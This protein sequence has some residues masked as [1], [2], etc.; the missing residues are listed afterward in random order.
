MTHHVS[1]GLALAGC[2]AALAAQR[3]P[4]VGDI[5]QRVGAYVDAYGGR[6]SIV[7]ATERYEQ[8]A[9][10]NRDAPARREIVSEFAIAMIED[11]GWQGFRDVVEVDGKPL[12]DRADRL[13]RALTSN[14]GSALAARQLSDESARFNIG[15]TFRNFN[16]PTTALFFFASRNLD[17]FKVSARDV[18]D[19][20]WRV[21]WRETARPTFIRTPRNDSVPTEGEL[22]VNPADGTIRRTR[23]EVNVRWS[24]N[25]FGGGR[26]DVSYQ[27]VDAI[28]MWLPASMDEQWQTTDRY[29][30]WERASGHAVYSNYRQFTTS[31]RIK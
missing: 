3:V 8:E 2:V 24:P 1:R 27:F 9:G 15:R 17:R 10:G 22:W 31:G 20:V 14:R 30:N 28:G 25:E 26:V 6:A 21:R 4:S 18:Q 16:V 12:A 5:M 7:V 29:G 23:L 11:S 19:G 13:V